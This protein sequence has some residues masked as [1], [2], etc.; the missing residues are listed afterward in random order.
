MALHTF[1]C[2]CLTLLHFKGLTQYDMICKLPQQ[3]NTLLRYLHF[4][5]KHFIVQ[6]RNSVKTSW[7]AQQEPMNDQPTNMYTKLTKNGEYFCNIKV[8]Q[9]NYAT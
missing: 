4:L 1:K 5:F 3:F 9:N 6:A 8:A 2:N 7:N